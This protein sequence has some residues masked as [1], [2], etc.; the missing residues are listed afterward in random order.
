MRLCG[1]N[2]SEGVVISTKVMYG[3]EQVYLLAGSHMIRNETK[4]SI[5]WNERKDFLILHKTGKKD[6][7]LKQEQIQYVSVPQLQCRSVGIKACEYMYEVQSVIRTV[8]DAFYLS[9][10]STSY[11]II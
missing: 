9:C 3:N 5:R 10:T 11:A 8:D 1:F 2:N 4:L 6:S 7:S